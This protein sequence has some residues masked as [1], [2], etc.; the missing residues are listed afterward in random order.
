[1][2]D[3]IYPKIKEGLYAIEEDGSVYSYSSK[4]YMKTSIDK[5]GYITISLRNTLG[6]YSHF[7]IHRLLMITYFPI[8]NM[9]EMTVN[10]ID[11]NKFNNSF[12]NLEWVTASENTRLAHETKYN[13]TVGEKHGKAKLTEEQAKRIIELIKEGRGTREIKK[14]IPFVTRNMVSQIK[15]NRTWKHLPR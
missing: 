9:E 12:D 10:H 13:N 15:H 6:G 4:K 8:D 14:E 3:I 7:G 2:K 1:M 11:G 5:D